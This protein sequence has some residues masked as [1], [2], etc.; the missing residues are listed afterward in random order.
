MNA[1][2]LALESNTPS[3]ME[4]MEA[5]IN[6]KLNDFP[7]VKEAFE[8]VLTYRL[9]IEGYLECK[10][11]KCLECLDPEEKGQFLSWISLLIQR[12]KRKQK[13]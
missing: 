5:F 11:N 3:D 8:S 9:N 12:R 2:P 4:W 13:N 10:V 7:L 1:I 6:Q